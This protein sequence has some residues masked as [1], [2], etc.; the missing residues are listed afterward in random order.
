M[1][2]IDNWGEAGSF[3]NK[4]TVKLRHKLFQAIPMPVNQNLS[5]GDVCLVL[6]ICLV[7]LSNSK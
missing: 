2:I 7:F 4:R 3:H 5:A 1:L 6:S